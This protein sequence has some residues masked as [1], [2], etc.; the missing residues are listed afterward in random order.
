LSNW[1]GTAAD[2]KEVAGS[3]KDVVVSEVAGGVDTWL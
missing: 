2:S 3:G 1:T